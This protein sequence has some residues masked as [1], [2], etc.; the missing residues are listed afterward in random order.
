MSGRKPCFLTATELAYGVR[1]KELLA[2]W[3]TETHLAQLASPK[4][5]VNAVVTL[6]PEEER[7][8]TP[9]SSARFQAPRTWEGVS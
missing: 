7:E 9:T 4:A 2:V 3:V 6:S 1:A 8:A 5:Q